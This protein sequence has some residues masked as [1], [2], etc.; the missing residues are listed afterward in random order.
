MHSTDRNGAYILF[1]WNI[2]QSW[3]NFMSQNKS[4]QIRDVEAIPSSF[5]DSNEMKLAVM[6]EGKLEKSEISWIKQHISE[7]LVS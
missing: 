4:Q 5:C 7:Q 6:E 1:D 3:E 2:V